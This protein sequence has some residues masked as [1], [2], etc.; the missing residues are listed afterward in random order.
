MSSNTQDSSCA[1]KTLENGFSQY[2]AEMLNV[3]SRMLNIGKERNLISVKSAFGGFAIYRTSCIP[4]DARYCGTYKNGEEKVDH[5][6]FNY[7]IYSNKP[8]KFFINPKLI[9]GT[10]PL[11]HTK[12][13]GIIG[14]NRFWLKMHLIDPFLRYISRKKRS[15]FS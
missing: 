8:G 10:S 1:K 15:L 14:M 6:D 9:I 12:Y 3:Y 11:E 13:A 5:L 7:S 4:K 2:H